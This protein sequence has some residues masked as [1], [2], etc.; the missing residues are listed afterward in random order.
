SNSGAIVV[1]GPGTGKTLL[2]TELATKH[3]RNNYSVL[4]VCF[5]KNLATHLHQKI[6]PSTVKVIHLHG[7]YSELMTLHKW[8]YQGSEENLF[9]QALPLFILQNIETADIQLFDYLI[10][11]EGQDLLNEYHFDVLNRL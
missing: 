10:I 5:N 1:G 9:D 11:D 2:A 8:H 7:L 4:L 3:E 6:H